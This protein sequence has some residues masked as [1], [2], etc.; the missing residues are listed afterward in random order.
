ME[1]GAGP[2]DGGENEGD[3]EPPA[4][5]KGKGS[6]PVDE[7]A[8][9]AKKEKVEMFKKL[10][11]AKRAMVEAM[12]MSQ[13]LLQTINSGSA[14]WKWANNPAV[15]APLSESRQQVEEFKV[16]STFYS[17]WCLETAFDKWCR[18]N[19]DEKTL[20]KEYKR[21]VTLEDLVAT[22][23]NEAQ[24]LKNMHDSRKAPVTKAGK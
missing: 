3:P 6:K 15:V 22:V 8:A 11:T 18:E 12:S 21:L 7:K 13:Q 10:A 4:G 20:R 17:S 5:K 23:V 19:C 2:T 1:P 16:S 9:K 24:M 14:S